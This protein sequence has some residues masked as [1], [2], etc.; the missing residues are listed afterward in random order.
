MVRCLNCMEMY[1]EK[2]GVCPR[3]GFIPGTPPKE[4][5]HL[6]PG[7]LLE[8]RYMIGTVL[9]FGGFGITYRAWDRI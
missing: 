3:C 4:A 5:Y 2:F 7:M 9:G 6:H 8:D 1:D